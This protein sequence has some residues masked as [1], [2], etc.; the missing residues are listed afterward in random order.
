M[1]VEA[2]NTHKQTC[3]EHSIAAAHVFFIQTSSFGR[4]PHKAAMQ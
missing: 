3:L 2:Q 4:T 1:R